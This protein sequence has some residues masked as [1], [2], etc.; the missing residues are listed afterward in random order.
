M[1]RYMPAYYP[2][3]RESGCGDAVVCLHATTSSSKQ[4]SALLERLAPQ[5]RVLAPDLAGH[6]RTPWQDRGANALE[7][8]LSLV[9]AATGGEAIHLVGHSYG[10]AVALRY[11]MRHPDRVRSLVLYEPAVW[12]L[13][14][15][16]AA[17]D[18]SA[19]RVFDVGHR[20]CELVE[21]GRHLEAAR[22]FIDYWNGQGSWEQMSAAHRERVAAQMARVA[23]HFAAVFIDRTP[24]VAYAALEMPALLISGGAGPRSGQRTTEL[25]AATMPRAGTRRFPGLGHMGPLTSPDEVNDAIAAFL[26]PLAVS[27]EPSLEASSTP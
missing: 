21:S 25:L 27:L 11:A 2:F 24:L 17:G 26:E 23:A 10:G 18:R 3:V 12:H 7:E 16:G 8:D 15:V 22:L 13:V 19:L 9:E 14:A 20:V 6:G 1:E 4:W 5:Y